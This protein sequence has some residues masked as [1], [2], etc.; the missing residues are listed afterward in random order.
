[1]KIRLG[2][3]QLISA[4]TISLILG[5]WYTLAHS[6][7]YP[8]FVLPS[9]ADVLRRLSDLVSEG[10][11]GRSLWE[12]YF[13]TLYRAGAGFTLACV[14]GTALGLSMGMSSKIHATFDPFIEFYRPIP[15]LAY[16]TLMVIWLGIGELSKIIFL[17][18]TALPP[19]VISTSSAVRGV[20]VERING[21][22]SLGAK[23]WQVFRYIT[24]PSCLP[25]ILTGVRL[26]F[27]MTY[28]TVVAAEMIAAA[29][30]LGFIV[31]H[32]QRY[33]RTDVI[34]LDIF[35]M[36]ITGIVFEQ[37]LRRIQ[38]NLVPWAGR[39]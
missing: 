27:S 29:S 21:A 15:P 9:P 22:R 36:A 32:A 4:A 16:L 17:Y 24:L 34:F 14:T 26:A 35:I 13:V 5:L 3:N 38:G 33:L 23:G 30:G 7:A 28:T 37:I 18:L 8:N 31:F 20:R 1:M 39:G 11:A 19:I 12:H 25:E 6:G 2:G 10:Y